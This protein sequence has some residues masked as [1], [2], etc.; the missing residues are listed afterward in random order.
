MVTDALGR[1][2]METAL[3]L[4]RSD[5]SEVAKTTSDRQ[6]R[7]TFS[8]IAPGTYAVT[9]DKADFQTGTAIVRWRSSW[10]RPSPS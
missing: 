9:A 1:P 8:G 6:G 10:H 2:L 5:G 7:F 4:Q 3:R